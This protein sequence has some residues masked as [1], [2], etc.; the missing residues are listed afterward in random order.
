M[1]KDIGYLLP[2]GNAYTEDMECCFIFVPAKDEYRRALFGALDYFGTWLAWQRDSEKRGQDAARAWKLANEYTRECWEM[3][4]C[5]LM[6]DKLDQL[7]ALQGNVPQCCGTNTNITYNDNRIETTTIVPGVGG[8][9]STYGETAVADWDEWKEYACFHAHNFVD[10][11][12][13]AA[14]KIDV[15]LDLGIWAIDAYFWL[16]RQIVFRDGGIAIPIDLSWAG[17]IFKGILQGGEGLFNIVA[18]DIESGRED[19]VCA[20]LNGTSV[21]DAVESVLT[22]SVAWTLFYQFIDYETAAAVIYNGEVEGMGYLI[23]TKRDD[24]DCVV[25]RDHYF[26]DEFP[27]SITDPPWKTNSVVWEAGTDGQV[28][29]DNSPD[30]MAL[31]K[32]G[33]NSILSTG[34]SFS[35]LI[36]RI[37][38]KWMRSTANTTP[39]VTIAADGGNWVYNWPAGDTLFST[40]YEKEIVFDPPKRLSTGVDKGVYWEGANFNNFVR[41][42]RVELDLDED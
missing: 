39:Y 3:G 12:I 13:N 21:E 8:A 7:I 4:A 34:G 36:H 17:V 20:F 10:D 15:L 31:N 16:V 9:P 19:I 33:L 25:P 35:F 14:N 1:S 29:M 26:V 2:D 22:P 18:D 24:C 23:P 11:L 37:K 28:K 30:Y 42:S 32:S 6:L 5:D 40:W 38:F 41:V 27:T